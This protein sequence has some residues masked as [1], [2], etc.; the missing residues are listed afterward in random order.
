MTNDG[1]TVMLDVRSDPSDQ[2]RAALEAALKGRPGIRAMDY[3]PHVRRILQ[4][5]YD[6]DAIKAAEIGRLVHEALGGQGPNTHIVG[7]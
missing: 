7:L 3:S 2:V 4:V 5:R 1:I 6:S